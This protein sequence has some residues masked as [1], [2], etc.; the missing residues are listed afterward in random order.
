[1]CPTAAG[2]S[3]AELA[4]GGRAGGTQSS[5]RPPCWPG[6]TPSHWPSCLSTP[7]KAGLTWTFRPHLPLLTPTTTPPTSTDRPLLTLLI[8]SASHTL[9]LYPSRASVPS[10]RPCCGGR[11]EQL[12]SAPRAHGTP[13]KSSGRWR[14]PWVSPS[15]GNPWQPQPTA[16]GRAGWPAA[17][18]TWGR[19]RPGCGGVLAG[20]GGQTRNGFTRAAA[21]MPGHR[22]WR[23]AKRYGRGARTGESEPARG[24]RAGRAGGVRVGGGV[25]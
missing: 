4:H 24:A 8:P 13:V 21:P 9:L 3:A 7:Y 16:G 14:P 25:P 1:M 6:V 2:I 19:R 11:G 22:S 23:D 18:T 20:T 12:L 5:Q 10:L 15:R 17:P